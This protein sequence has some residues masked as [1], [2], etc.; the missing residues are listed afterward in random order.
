MNHSAKQLTNTQV[1][2]KAWLIGLCTHQS[3]LATLREEE[4]MSDSFGAQ[5]KLK[6][7]HED[8]LTDTRK[9]L[10]GGERQVQ[11]ISDDEHWGDAFRD[12]P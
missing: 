1:T 3:S 2:D 6:R 5:G 9:E 8:A 10:A 11:S 12:D 7:K 4:Q